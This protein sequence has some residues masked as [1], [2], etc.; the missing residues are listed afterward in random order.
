MLSCE[1]ADAVC[2]VQIPKWPVFGRVCVCA[3]V[4]ACVCVCVCVC[5]CE[6]MCMRAGACLHV[7][8]FVLPCPWWPAEVLIGKLLHSSHHMYMHRCT[9]FSFTHTHI[10]TQASNIHTHSTDMHRACYCHLSFQDCAACR[11]ECGHS[12]RDVDGR[13]AK[14]RAT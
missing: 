9:Q 14:P 5:V 13:L 12:T 4:R 11:L 6:C 3:C 1:W 10:R 7:F 2:S 8:V